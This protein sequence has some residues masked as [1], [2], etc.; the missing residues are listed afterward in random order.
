MT[1]KLRNRSLLLV[2]LSAGLL[3]GSQGVA[4]APG[5]RRCQIQC[6]I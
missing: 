1:L 5:K 2:A 3:L 4:S 6:S